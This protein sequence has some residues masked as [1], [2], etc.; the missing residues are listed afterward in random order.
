M[1][2]ES[3]DSRPAAAALAQRVGPSANAAQITD[4]IVSIWQEIDAALCP[5]IGQR[6]VAAL[7]KRSLYLTA[8]AHPGLAGI[9]EGVQTSIDTAP[10]GSALSKQ[11]SDDARAAGTVLLNNFNGLLSTLIGP[12]LTE[13][14]LRAVW[15][16]TSNG[17]P[18]QDTSR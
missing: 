8:A 14:L 16:N 4:A 15:A 3:Q 1:P 12:S 6:G 9:G 13:R 11:N 2:T 7:Y 10:L 17:T 18:F 5:I